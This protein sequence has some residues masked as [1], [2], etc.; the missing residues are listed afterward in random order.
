M[1]ERSWNTLV[2]TRAFAGLTLCAAS[3]YDAQVTVLCKLAKHLK[4][5][6]LSSTTRD[7]SANI[8]EHVAIPVFENS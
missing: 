1:A 2:L 8:S 4:N 5:S 3:V 7:T 6:N